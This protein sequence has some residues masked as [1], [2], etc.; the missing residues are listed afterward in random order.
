MWYYFAHMDIARYLRYG[1][2]GAL[3]CVPFIPLIILNGS[4]FPFI[5]GK[6]F[7]FRIV[8]ELAGGMW[9]AL[10]L[11]DRTYRPRF[12]VVLWSV[13]AFTLAIGAADLFG[14]NAWKSF[15]SNFERMEGYI[16]IL[17]LAVYVIVAASVFTTEKLWRRYFGTSLG[18][19]TLITLYGFMQLSGW[20]T[21]NQ[22]G[23]RLDGTFGNA[24]YLAVYMLVHVF[25]TAWLFFTYHGTKA[26]WMK[27][28]YGVM[29]VLQAIILYFTATRGA[30]L[31]L[32]GGIFLTALLFAFTVRGNTRVRNVSFGILGGLVLLVG[33]FMLVRDT[34]FVKNHEVLG[35]FATIS[36]EGGQTRFAVWN[37]ALQGVKDRPILGFG[38]E[39]FIYVFNQYYNPK[40]FGQ[41]PWFDRVH[42]VF[43]D[44]LIAGGIVGLLSYLAMFGAALYGLWLAPRAKE[45]FTSAE[46]NILTGL[47]AGYFFHNIFVFD[48]IVSYILFFTMLAFIHYRLTVKGTDPDL[49]D[50]HPH[51]TGLPPQVVLPG[52]IILTCLVLYFAN[53]AGLATN[54]TLLRAISP[55]PGGP[56]ENLAL[57]KKVLAY[58]TLGGQEVKEQLLQTAASVSRANGIDPTLKEDF[59]RTAKDAMDTELK[60]N[61]EDARLQVFMGSFLNGIGMPAEALPY[62]EKASA[63]SPT[64]QIILFELGASYTQLG[65]H[66]EALETLKKAYELEPSYRQAALSYAAAAIHAGDSALT[67]QI[68]TPIYGTTVV[69]NDQILAAYFQ[70]KQ[71]SIVTKIWEERVKNDPNNLQS[72][73]SLAAAYLFAERRAESIA[74]LQKAMEIDPTFKEQGEYYISEIRAGRNP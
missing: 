57:F 51:A 16:T 68:L 6:N 41:E 56:A 8:V 45:A 62:L 74:Q 31:G 50:T 20:I 7:F 69:D 32:L 60:W 12:G 17:H 3:F 73:V 61:G 24:T 37:T 15:W 66:K 59:I 70:T 26:K 38:Q 52:A 64:K 65:R 5:V 44:W 4:F 27:S 39:N 21:I 46:R 28:F 54:I 72:R 67:S 40:M 11:I 42:N 25:L 10:M 30:I 47:F 58:D 43:L 36:L 2:F 22:G 19:S 48:N 29:I 1:I 63:L 53:Y 18:V 9:L 35:R 71:Y 55:N 13:V 34:D 14:V 23:V 49:L 33:G